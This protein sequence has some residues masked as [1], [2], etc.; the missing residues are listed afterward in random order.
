MLSNLVRSTTRQRARALLQDAGLASKLSRARP[1]PQLMQLATRSCQSF[2]G[3]VRSRPVLCWRRALGASLLLASCGMLAAPTAFSLR[4]SPEGPAKC[5]ETPLQSDKGQDAKAKSSP[6][7]TV[8]KVSAALF[9][10]GLFAGLW[11]ASITLPAALVWAASTGRWKVVSSIFAAYCF[12]HMVQ[13][14]ALP[15]SIRHGFWVGLEG[16]FPGGIQVVHSQSAGEPEP[17]PPTQR[18]RLFCIHPHGIYTIGALTLPDQMPEVRLCM[19]PYLYNFSPAFRMAA[20]LLGI[21]VGSTGPRALRRL[22]RKGE[23]P[24]ALVPGGFEEA[25]VTSPGTE[26]VFLKTR[27]GFVK[28]ALRHGYDARLES[29]S[30]PLQSRQPADL[31][32]AVSRIRDVSREWKLGLLVAKLDVRGAFDRISRAKV[33]S[34]LTS[35]LQL[36]GLGRE[37]RYLLLQLM[38]NQLHGCVPG[39]GEICIECDIGIKQGSP[40]SAEL[41]GVIME[42][43]LQDVRHGMQWRSFPEPLGDVGIDMLQYQDDVFL[44]ETAVDNLSRKIGL[45]DAALQ[46]VGLELAM[47]KTAVIASEHYVGNRLVRIGAATV[48]VLPASCTIRVLGLDFSFE[49]FSSRQARD[50]VAKARAAVLWLSPLLLGWQ[51]PSF[52]PLT[53]WHFSTRSKHISSEMLFDSVA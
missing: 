2:P 26:R 27:A 7:A 3:P 13:L 12:P 4:S 34:F 35:R 45:I 31:V 36:Q 33:A 5:E 30:R 44:F 18:K 28:Y 14:P 8:L 46:A 41:F 39:G 50:L 21:K 24:L 38:P 32:G 15:R 49:G 37:L 17:E 43:V 52:G 53:I 23:S 48:E 51:G 29:R 10:W 6:V 16:W 9:C 11:F 22:M 20:D 1:G 40:E 42:E 47:D 25:T 19:A